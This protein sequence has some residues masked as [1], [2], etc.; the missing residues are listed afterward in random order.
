MPSLAA[1]MAETYRYVVGVD[2]HAGVRPEL[3]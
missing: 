2:T 3:G 1:T